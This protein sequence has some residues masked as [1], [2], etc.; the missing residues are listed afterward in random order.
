MDKTLKYKVSIFRTLLIA[1][2]II[3]V[4]L[5]S[6]FYED[7]SEANKATK[8]Q[9]VDLKDPNKVITDKEELGVI[10]KEEGLM[11]KPIRI[12]YEY[13]GPTE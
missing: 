8:D 10:A 13:N 11:K 3:S 9:R 4:L 1:M 12:E 5:G 2:V 6:H 7:S